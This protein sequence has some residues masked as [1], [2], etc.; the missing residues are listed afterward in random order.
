MTKECHQ[1]PKY[2]T[3]RTT[4][5]TDDLN[6]LRYDSWSQQQHHFITRYVVRLFFVCKKIKR[7]FLSLSRFFSVS[8]LHSISAML[9]H[10]EVAEQSNCETAAP[11]SNILAKINTEVCSGRAVHPA[12]KPVDLDLHSLFL[13]ETL[14]QDYKAVAAKELQRTK[15]KKKKALWDVLPVKQKSN[16][17]ALGSPPA[18]TQPGNEF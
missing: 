10:F 18:V 5:R 4:E 1:Q 7:E 6:S 14:L 16:G 13:S 2:I 11:E 12:K 8:L 15:L 9:V 17:L 3:R